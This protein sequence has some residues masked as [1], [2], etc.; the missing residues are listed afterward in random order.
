MLPELPQELFLKVLDSVNVSDD[1]TTAKALRLVNRAL[2]LR[3]ARAVWIVGARSHYLGYLLRLTAYQRRFT[4]HLLCGG[5]IGAWSMRR[6]IRQ[7]ASNAAEATSAAIVNDA[8]L[9]RQLSMCT[10]FRV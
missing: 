1:A 7:A 4:I 3:F 10:K 9:F 5:E 8:E 2:A 6:T